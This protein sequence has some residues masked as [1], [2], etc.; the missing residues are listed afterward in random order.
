MKKILF[1]V[2]ALLILSSGI[3]QAQ[4]KIW[5]PY[6]R[7]RCDGNIAERT[8]LTSPA[9]LSGDHRFADNSSMLQYHFNLNT[10]K[11][12]NDMYPLTMRFYPQNEYVVKISDTPITSVDQG[13]LV[14]IYTTD[15]SMPPSRNGA[16]NWVEIPLKQYYDMN[17][18]DIYLSFFDGRPQDGW[19]PSLGSIAFCYQMD[20]ADIQQKG[21]V[22]VNGKDGFIKVDGNFND[23]TST[24]WG[25]L[26]QGGANVISNGTIL[27]DDDLSAKTAV[28]FDKQNI[29]FA[30]D[31]KDS[32]GIV[33]GDSLVFYIG[34][35]N[36]DTLPSLGHQALTLPDNS[37]LTGFRNHV[38]CDY[39]FAI[40]IN[41]TASSINESKIINGAVPASN[42]KV[43]KTDA[44]YKLEG[45][46]PFASLFVQDSVNGK[47]SL[48][49]TDVLPYTFQIKTPRATMVS[50]VD[51]DYEDS[52]ANWGY[53]TFMLKIASTTDSLD[54]KILKQMTPGKDDQAFV[55]SQYPG[56]TD[57]TRRWADG[58]DTLAYHF[59]VNKYL[60]MVPNQDVYVSFTVSNEYKI[61]YA[62]AVDSPKTNFSLWSSKYIPVTD[63]TNQADI[64]MSLLS[65]QK[66]GITDLNVFFTD[67]LPDDAFG[68]SVTNIKIYCKGKFNYTNTISFT[69]GTGTNGDAA[70]LVADN[71]SGANASHRWADGNSS[72]GYKF[73]LAALKANMKPSTELFFR[74]KMQNE[75]VVSVAK[76]ENDAQTEIDRWSSANIPVTDGSNAAYY[77]YSLKPYMDAGWSTVVF[78]FKDGIP[79]DGWGPAL[80]DAN[81]ASQAIQCY[82]AFDSFV[83]STQVTSEAQYLVDGHVGSGVSSSHRWADG[84]SDICYHFNKIDL[85]TKSNGIDNIFVSYSLQNE[86]VVSVAPGLDSTRIQDKIWSNNDTPVHDGSNYTTLQTNL[87]QYFDKGWNDVYLFFT[88]GRPQ[89]G[90]GPSVYKVTLSTL[91]DAVLGVKK[92]NNVVPTKFNVYQNYPNPFN[93]E[94]TIRYEIPNTGKVTLTVYD[95]LGREIKTLINNVQTSGTYQVTWKG[96]NNYGMKVASGIYLYKVNFD[97]SMQVAKKMLLLK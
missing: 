15:T 93:P 48:T 44:G 91:Q 30:A 84:N 18:T 11:D 95:I 70:Y 86:Y 1:T 31:V 47:Y 52:P 75:F 90:W 83:P 77:Q 23:W 38:E 16:G 56:Q 37:K 85:L 94:T 19:G 92:I 76:T 82:Y 5:A 43:F 46:I 6:F 2:F 59:D 66:K 8:F 65:M 89:D 54:Q 20:E 87:K 41:I 67:G 80:F 96:D 50:A 29:Y 73:D 35:Y 34:T 72:F 74:V 69:P 26:T 3:I 13:E 81:I 63:G 24:Q 22:A 78:F 88:D 51:L 60:A 7:F 27:N 68:P 12:F 40:P 61:D 21:L 49:D 4:S 28:C 55:L 79:T 42:V 71:G 33:A 53:R 58:H 57:G 17:K 64:E 97:N 25:E 14:A 36:I 45:M 9:S 32:K 10:F 39:R 62:S